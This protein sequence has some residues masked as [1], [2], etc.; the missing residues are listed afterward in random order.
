MSDTPRKRK[1]NNP[2]ENIIGLS[3]LY[4]NISIIREESMSNI[5]IRAPPQLLVGKRHDEEP[6]LSVVSS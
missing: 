4:V 1:R 3:G 6:K 5:K 2:D